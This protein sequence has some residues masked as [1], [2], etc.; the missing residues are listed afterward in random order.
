MKQKI[1]TCIL[2]ICAAISSLCLVLCLLKSFASIYRSTEFALI[3]CSFA[4]LI[5]S[6]L[7]FR[8]PRT[9][10]WVGLISGLGALYWFYGVE[11]GY[12]FPALNT[13]VAFNLPDGTPDSS[14]DILIAKLKIAFAIT[15]FA[16]A[17]ISATRL[18][19]ARW[20]MRKRLVQDRLWPALAACVLAALFWYSLSVSPY[21]IP[22][23][24]DAMS[25]KL[26]LLHVEKS[27]MQ[28]RETGISVLE[29][30]EVY[31]FHND[32]RLFQYRFPV[33]TG[34]AVLSQDSATR[35]AALA[36]AQELA[37]ADTAPAVPL[38]SKEAEGWYVRTQ[39]RHIL[40]FTTEDGT[41]APP[42]LL[43]LF[44]SLESAVPATKQSGE[45]K[46][47]CFGFCYDPLAGLGIVYINERCTDRNGTHCK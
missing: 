35:G 26:T 19:P 40:A 3:A 25:A 38:R 16:A 43:S 32:R 22:L 34:S 46:D 39:Y 15:A 44:R 41:P 13:W 24:V 11:F 12:L 2:Y 1:T 33:R 37:N 42:K 23:I 14:R 4:F 45:E 36:L 31:S 47:I 28:F 30:G 8:W 10:H 17:A 29:D 21:R 20:V 9:S 18:L 7:V 5:A 6:V 27:G